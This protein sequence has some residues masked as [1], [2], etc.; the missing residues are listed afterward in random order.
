M[1]VPYNSIPDFF[2]Y[3]LWHYC[4]SF[5]LSIVLFVT[6]YIVTIT[7]NSYSLHQ[8]RMK[9]KI[10]FYAIIYSFFD[11]LPF[12][13]LRFCMYYFLSPSKIYFNISCPAGLSVMNSLRFC[14]SEKSSF[15]F[16]F[17]KLSRCINNPGLVFILLFQPVKYFSLWFFLLLLV[18]IF[19][20]F[21]FLFF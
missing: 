20:Y 1:Q 16:N 8:L 13:N 4:Q 5:H 7:L 18:F 9:I 10:C 6:Q 19:L 11:T 2:S 21:Y 14:F 3:S 17:D 12:I 15:L